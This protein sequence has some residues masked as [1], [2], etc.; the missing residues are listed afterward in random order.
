MS[1]Q[2]RLV[3]EAARFQHPAWGVS[4][5]RRVYDLAVQLGDSSGAGASV[6]KD[7]LFAAAY[8]H[9]LG[10]FAPY[11]REGVDHAERSVEVAAEILVAAGFGAPKVPLVQEIVRGHMYYAEPAA[12]PEAVY[13]HDA[14][15]LDFMGA[16]GIARLLSIVGRD[17]WTPDLPAAI[18]LIDRFR[19]ELPGR[20][21]TEVARRIGEERQRE[22]DAFVAALA[23]ETHG[24]QVL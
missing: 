1:W 9:D 17:D 21:H 4:H 16:V 7:A 23:A 11:R 12:L 19:R 15:V 20:L 10:A 14:D 6:D 24:L 22:M 8:V 5:C 18:A 2:E 13:F 3:E